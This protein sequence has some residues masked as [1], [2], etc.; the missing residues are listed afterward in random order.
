MLRILGFTQAS[1]MPA[2]LAMIQQHGLDMGVMLQ[3]PNEFR[4]AIPRV[5]DDADTSLQVCIYSFL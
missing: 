3:N 2:V 5:P 1:M 4:P